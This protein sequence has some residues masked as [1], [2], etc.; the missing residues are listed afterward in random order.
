MGLLAFG[1]WRRIARRNVHLD[2]EKRQF[3]AQIE[4]VARAARADR[5]AYLSWEGHRELRVSAIVDESHGVKS[6]YL[7]DP[8][9]Q[10]LPS[11]E[12]GQYLTC[13]FDTAEGEK[14]LVRCYSLSDRP[15]EEYYRL[16]VKRSDPPDDL[17]DAPPGRASNRL[18]RMTVGDAFRAAAPRGE[19]FLDPRRSDP[20][21]LVAGGI[22]VT[23]LLS[24]IAALV[25][26]GDDREVYFFY[27]VRNSSEHPLREQLAEL[28]ADNSHIHTFVAYTQPLQSDQPFIDYHHGSRIT[29]DYLRQV[30]P[31]GRFDYYLCGPGEMMQSLVEGLLDQGVPDDRILYEAFGP[32]SVQRASTAKAE[33]SANLHGQPQIRFASSHQ[34]AEWDD[35]CSSLLEL[36]EQAGV[37]IDAGCR[38]G[39]CG[40]C[41]TRVLDGEFTTVKPSGAPLPEGH[42]LA[43]I[44]VPTSPL[45]LEL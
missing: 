8:E 1:G 35:Q 25:H 2:A 28:V 14:P 18:H 23:P 22:G 11:Y 39:S 40:M 42:C 32:S 44:S 33:T 17:P 5:Q 45:V 36:I 34:E 20:L 31:T 19:F 4:A 6:F 9:G 29:V 27:S 26:A 30:L 16:T 24:M 43:C 12:P 37:A 10:S 13:H 3:V 7:T 21:V 41:A 38:A 15:R